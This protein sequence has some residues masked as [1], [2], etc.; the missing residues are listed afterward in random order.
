MD[1]DQEAGQE[2]QEQELTQEDQEQELAQEDQ[3]QEL[4]PRSFFSRMRHFWTSLWTS[5]GD[6]S[7]EMQVGEE[8]S[9]VGDESREEVQVGGE[10]REEEQVG[11]ESRE[12]VQV[13]GESLG[14]ESALPARPGLLFYLYE[15]FRRASV[16]RTSSVVPT[17]APSSNSVFVFCLKE[18][19]TGLIWIDRTVKLLAE[20]FKYLGYIVNEEL[21]LP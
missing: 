13:G 9:Q 16:P 20:I 8:E 21:D 17:F 12:E 19:C 15:R 11:G 1:E 7:D 2:D 6:E 5:V 18:A 14:H 10:S 4:V 3:E